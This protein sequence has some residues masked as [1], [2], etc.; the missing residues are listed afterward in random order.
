MKSQVIKLGDFGIAKTLNHTLEC[1]QTAIGT[2]VYCCPE[3]CHNRKYNQKSDIWSLGVVLYELCTGGQLPFSGRNLKTLLAQICN[4]PYPTSALR[5][6]S[7]GVRDLIKVMLMKDPSQRPNVNAILRHRV[8]QQTLATMSL[9]HHPQQPPGNKTNI[10]PEEEEEE[11]ASFVPP[12]SSSSGK[13][14]VTTKPA[15][16]AKEE[17]VA[18]AY[19]ANQRGVPTNPGNKRVA[20]NPA[21]TK[22]VTPNPGTNPINKRVGTNPANQRVVTPNPVINGA[23]TPNLAPNLANARVGANIAEQGG[24]VHP[25]SKAVKTKASAKPWLAPKQSS[26]PATKPVDMEFVPPVPR[27]KNQNQRRPAMPPPAPQ[28]TPE[29]LERAKAFVKFQSQKKKAKPKTTAPSTGPQVAEMQEQIAAFQL[30][31]QA[32]RHGIENQLMLKPTK[33]P[34]AVFP[35]SP[36][37][38]SPGAQPLPPPPSVT[39]TVQDVAQDKSGDYQRMIDQLQSVMG[40]LDDEETSSRSS[41]STWSREE[42]EPDIPTTTTENKHNVSF[43]LTT[44]LQ[45]PNVFTHFYHHPEELKQPSISSMAL[46]DQASQVLGDSISGKDVQEWCTQLNAFLDIVQSSTE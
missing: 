16:V 13:T 25:A 43:V 30:Q 19:L 45:H 46:L 27:W 17:P 24:A 21:K 39:Y 10:P 1:A 12:R 29:Q 33:K 26:K 41:S 42:N 9:A 22:V 32:Q 8:L 4:S 18:V 44:L 40:Q 28:P 15:V 23:V 38:P 5:H 11:E 36:S 31:W 37:V 34:E 2:P 7:P 20:S 3:I 35:S 6:M 14:V